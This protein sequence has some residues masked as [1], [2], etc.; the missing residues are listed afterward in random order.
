MSEPL[1]VARLGNG[2]LVT[3]LHGWG[4]GASVFNPLIESLTERMEVHNVDLPGYGNSVWNPSLTFEA[5]ASLISSNVPEG[6]LLGWSMGGLYAIEMVRQNPGQ[7]KQLILIASN[8]CF[9]RRPDWISALDETVFT[10]FARDLDEGKPWGALIKRFVSLQ[11]LGAENAR[12]CARDQLN[13]VSNMSVPDADALK[14][15]LEL[16][17]IKDMRSALAQI[18][19]PVKLILGDCDALIPGT[20]SGEIS[21]VNPAIQVE[22]LATA[23]HL[24]FVSHTEQVAAMI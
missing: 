4:M 2:P 11:M 3:F 19:I 17:L 1:S 10:A 7:F 5:Q 14:F 13:R 16:L 15:G 12:Q 20:L 9:V 22:S 24:P 6:V 8:P 18:D 21:K 23:A